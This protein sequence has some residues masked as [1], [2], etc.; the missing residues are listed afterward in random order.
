MEELKRCTKCIMPNTKPDL[1]FDDEGVCDACQSSEA[2]QLIDWD[3]REKEFCKVL[4]KYKNKD[5]SNYDCIIPVSGGKDSTFQTYMIK[6]Y[7]LNPLCVTWAPAMRTDL[8]KKNI[9]GLQRLGVDHIQFTANPVTY[10]KLFKEALIRLGDPCWSC[11][12]GIFTYPVRIAVLYKVPLIIWGEN[13]QLE[14]GGP[15]AARKSHI[16]D[17]RWL[18]EFGGLMGNRLEAMVSDDIPMRDLQSLVYPSKEELDE[19]GVTGIFL[20][21]YFKWD[22]MAQTEIIKKHGFRVKEDGPAEGCYH[23]YENLDCKLNVLHTYLKYL[24]FGFGKATD[25]LCLDI[26]H[27]RMTREKALEE[28]KEFDGT[29]P[30][31]HLKE[32]CQYLDVTEEE[33]WKITESFR[34]Y[35]WDHDAKD[36]DHS[37]FASQRT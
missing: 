12:L 21:T 32:I 6:K 2:K 29:K 5:G 25:H 18:H 28:I 8:G 20:G 33:L 24:K 22:A 7:G 19:V 4:E 34:G 16:L 31:E 30:K 27:K 3:A 13:P 35:F 36:E 26:R 11:H 15:E 10:R 37:V 14:Y 9:E 23:N 17:K 1:S